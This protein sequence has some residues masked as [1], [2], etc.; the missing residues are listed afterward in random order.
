MSSGSTFSLFSN[1]TIL[2]VTFYLSELFLLSIKKSLVSEIY[3]LFV[4]GLTLD[5]ARANMHL[6]DQCFINLFSAN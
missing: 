3:I 1:I 5:K 2:L 6:H 4:T